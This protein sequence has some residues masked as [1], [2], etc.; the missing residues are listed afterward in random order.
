[1]DR[2]DFVKKLYA[3]IFFVIG[4]LLILAVVFVIGMEKGLTQPKFQVRVVFRDVGGLSVGAPVRLCGVN[5]GTVGKI[6]FLEEKVDGRGVDVTLNLFKRYRR[7]VEK[8]TRFTIK[9]EGIL[10]QKLIAIST[11]NGDS[12]NLAE[13][14]LGEDPL[15]VQDLAESFDATAVSLQEASDNINKML[16]QL[17][18]ASK[19]FKRLVDRIEQRI[20]DGDLFKVF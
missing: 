12:F 6:D 1:M 14:V 11:E 19:T 8:G 18:H 3:G 16:K 10:G 5:I 9:T 17:E 2:K 20:I 7:Q 13:T 4:I 15:D